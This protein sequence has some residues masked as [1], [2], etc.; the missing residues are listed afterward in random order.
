MEDAYQQ[1]V[2]RFQEL[3]LIIMHTCGG[4][5][6]RAPELLGV[7]WKNTEQ[8]G[9]RTIFIHNGFNVAGLVGLA[10]SRPPP[11][12]HL[13]NNRP[14]RTVLIRLVNDKNLSIRSDK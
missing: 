11:H 1:L 3:L 2:E 4:Q 10:A 8:G 5:A 13:D 12:N 9:V 7:R 6:A 14:D